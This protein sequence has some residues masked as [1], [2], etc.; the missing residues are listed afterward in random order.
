M[1][2][3]SA[4]AAARSRGRWC[5][6]WSTWDL[7][8]AQR[9]TALRRQLAQRRRRDRALLRPRGR[10]PAVSGRRRSVHARSRRG[11]YFVVVVAAVAVQTHRRRDRGPARAP[12]SRCTSSAAARTKARCAPLAARNAHDVSAAYLDDAALD[13]LVGR[14]ARGDRRGRRR[15][16]ARCAR[17]RRRRD[18]RRSRFRGG[19]ALET[20]VEGVTGEFFDAPDRAS[21]A[22]AIGAL[23]PRAYEPARLRA[24]AETLRA[25]ALHRAPAARSSRRSAHGPRQSSSGE[26]AQ[27]LQVG[28]RGRSRDANAKRADARAARSLRV[29]RRPQTTLRL[30]VAP[31]VDGRAGRAAARRRRSL[32]EARLRWPRSTVAP[33][34]IA[35]TATSPKPSA[36]DGTATAR[37]L[38]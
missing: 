9:P 31:G 29:S 28:A 1:S 14:R 10:R 24:H 3:A 38:R 21:L 6:R 34:A 11:D 7:R 5:A 18:A 22:A 30:R 26:P 4:A 2:A 36:V 23:R 13:A 35:S 15:L 33:Q 19:G 27:Q 37:A 32:R 12:A 20:I 25:G 8:A 16:R 17:G